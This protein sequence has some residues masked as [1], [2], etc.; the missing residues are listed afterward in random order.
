MSE[1]EKTPDD[2]ND[3]DGQTYIDIT[4]ITEEK[5][6]VLLNQLIYLQEFIK[7]DVSKNIVENLKNGTVF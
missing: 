7:S 5:L 4:T 2:S 6:S 1:E 3:D